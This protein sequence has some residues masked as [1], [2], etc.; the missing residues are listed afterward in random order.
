MKRDRK[1]DILYY[2]LTSIGLLL[3]K[4]IRSLT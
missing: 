3:R 2:K 4:E 1:K